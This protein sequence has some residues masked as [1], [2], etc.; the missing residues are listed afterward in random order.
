MATGSVKR[1]GSG[2][3]PMLGLFALLL[4]SL[5]LM[6]DATH[7]SERFGQ[8]YSVL[9]AINAFGLILLSAL[10]ITNIISLVRQHRHKAVGARMTS[11][12]V[13]MF[14]ILSLAPVLVSITFP[15]S[16]FSVVSTAGS[17]CVSSRD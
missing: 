10:V 9:L 15:C 8:I 5:Y 7:N 11:R 2:F 4:V 13:I 1:I 16:R 12:L 3:I 14:I 17:M 6:S